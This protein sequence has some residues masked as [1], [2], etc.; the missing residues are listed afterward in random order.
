M[1][2]S[3]LLHLMSMQKFIFNHQNFQRHE[4]CLFHFSFLMLFLPLLACSKKSSTNSCCWEI[5]EG[6]RWK[7][8]S[9]ANDLK[10]IKAS[11]MKMDLQKLT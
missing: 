8:L 2:F 5:P 7:S 4:N 10:Y 1:L 9:S 3:Q 6:G 11:L